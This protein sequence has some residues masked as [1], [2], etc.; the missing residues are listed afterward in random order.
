MNFV[1]HDGKMSGFRYDVETLHD[2]ELNI[3][4]QPTYSGSQ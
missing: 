1:G 2:V 4:P 3:F